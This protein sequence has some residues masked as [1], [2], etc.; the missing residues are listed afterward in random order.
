MSMKSSETNK[1]AITPLAAPQ[2]VVEPYRSEFRAGKDVLYAA[3]G[4]GG[5]SS[6][7]IIQVLLRRWPWM[8]ASL[9]LALGVGLIVISTQQRRYAASTEVVVH[10]QSVYSHSSMDDSLPTVNKIEDISTNRSVFTQV[11]VLHSPDLLAQALQ[12]L[13]EEE[14]LKAPMVEVKEPDEKDNSIMVT[15]TALAPRAAADMANTLIKL[16]I[17]HDLE[18]SRKTASAA[19]DYV[20]NELSRISGELHTARREL[21]QFQV[22]NEVAGNDAV[23]AQRTEQ[24]SKLRQDAE[25]AARM[26]AISR[27]LMTSFSERLHAESRQILTDETEEQNPVLDKIDMEINDLET[28]RLELLQEFTPDSPEVKRVTRTIDAARER[29]TRVLASRISK[30][31]RGLNPLYQQLSQQY[32]AALTDAETAQIRLRVLQREIATMS[33]HLSQLPPLESR[34][35]ELIN[36]VQ[37]LEETYGSLNKRYQTLKIDKASYISNIRVL[38]QAYPNPIPVSPN[39]PRAL[40]L[41]LT[42]GI[43]LAIVLT[44]TLEASDKRIHSEQV[45]QRL[46]PHPVL[47]QI[48]LAGQGL[49]PQLLGE[50]S[51]GNPMLEQTRLLRSGLALMAQGTPERIIAVTS[52]GAGDGKST[53]AINLAVTMAMDG[54]RVVLVDADLRRPSLHTYLGVGNA[55]GLTSAI[56]E[57]IPV[58]E[59][60]IP[61][62][63]NGVMLLASGPLAANPPEVLANPCMQRLI[64]ELST[65][66]DVVIIDAAPTAGLSDTLSLIP[67]VDGFLMVISNGRTNQDQLQVALRTLGQVGAPILGIVYNR[68]GASHGSYYYYH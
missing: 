10:D 60:L 39:I 36:K 57:G 24:L 21:S 27:S 22:Q 66:F 20:Q 54:K 26:V 46:T 67:L 17:A 61:T 58:E 64:S 42:L 5:L 63:V 51:G 37:L 4:A 53:T 52:P 19:L 7:D 38:S 2:V 30:K 13:P 45:V 34:A 55:H 31:T 44:V 65:Q 48:P 43:L 41:S 40:V 28:H 32:Q 3:S 14:R 49:R 62:S 15:V 59:L 35:E 25:E 8:V 50:L 18:E 1:Q 6:H 11:K 16:F 9:L 33:S 68:A 12:M 56:I 23:L 29:R 47:A